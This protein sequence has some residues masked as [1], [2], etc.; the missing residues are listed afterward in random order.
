MYFNYE[1]TYKY[2][3]FNLQA[4]MGYAQ[5]QRIDELVGKKNGIYRSYR[6][7]LA[8]IDDIQLNPE[9]EYVYNGAWITGLL[10][11][12]S[13]GL[14]K[15]E[16]IRLLGESG[17]P[18]RPFFYPLSSLP[19]FGSREDEHREKNPVAYD[20]C[21]RGVNLPGALILTEEQIDEVCDGVRKVLEGISR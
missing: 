4:A 18:A 2:M 3:P 10:P 14:D 17:V 11:G 6:E 7:R 21:Y 9:P 20:I 5:F 19:A 12:K 1:V 16:L 15:L 13:Y 8:D